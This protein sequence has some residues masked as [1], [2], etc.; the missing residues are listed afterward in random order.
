M[1]DDNG[2]LFSFTPNTTC[3]VPRGS[4]LFSFTPNTT[5]GVPWGSVLFTL[6]TTL[7][8][9]IQSHNVDHHLYTNDTQIYISLATPYINCSLNQLRHCLHDTF[10][11]MT[12]SKLKLNANKTEFFIIGTQKQR[13][14]L[15]CF[16]PF[17]F[18]EQEFH[19]D[20]LGTEFRSHL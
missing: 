20:R 17:T 5:C 10:H 7:S 4:V 1:N 8:S 16:F 19:T 6:Y 12:N 15:D 14:K 11:W 18:A 13:G 9:V 3:G 2:L